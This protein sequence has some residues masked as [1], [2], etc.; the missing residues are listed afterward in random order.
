MSRVYEEPQISKEKRQFKRKQKQPRGLEQAFHK[1][2][3][4]QP[5]NIGK[6]CTTNSL[7]NQKN[8]KLKYTVI[9]LYPITVTWDRQYW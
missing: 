3:S 5:V 2:I 6:T 4:K 8:A 7:K 9:P 1:K